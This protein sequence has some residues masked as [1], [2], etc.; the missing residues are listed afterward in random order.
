M[1]PSA[2]T[3]DDH[4]TRK[5]IEA[6]YWF[7]NAAGDSV[8]RTACVESPSFDVAGRLGSI[9]LCEITEADLADREQWTM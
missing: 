5:T 4:P 8:L 2:A 1:V 7:Q 6:M 3:V 9:V